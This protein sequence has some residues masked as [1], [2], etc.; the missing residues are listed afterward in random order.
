MVAGGLGHRRTALFW[1]VLMAA[2]AAAAL[3]ALHLSP[4][5]Q[6]AMVI[7]WLAIYCILAAAL[8]RRFPVEKSR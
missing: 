6:W 2:V 4:G 8:G 7:C 3:A 1:Y 5:L